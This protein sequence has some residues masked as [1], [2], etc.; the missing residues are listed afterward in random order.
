MSGPLGRRAAAEFVGTAALVAVVV[1]GAVLADA[2]APVPTPTAAPTE[3]GLA[4]Y[5]P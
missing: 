2:P 4:A 1:G 5:R 3:P